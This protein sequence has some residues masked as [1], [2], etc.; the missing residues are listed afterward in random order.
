MSTVTAG[1]SMTIQCPHQPDVAAFLLGALTPDEERA[2][3]VHLSTC[4][5]CQTVLVEFL[6]LPLRLDQ[7]PR[8]LLGL[9][10]RSRGGA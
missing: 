7:V 5:N 4:A 10:D 6:K 2:T 8:S 9:I 1:G 3:M